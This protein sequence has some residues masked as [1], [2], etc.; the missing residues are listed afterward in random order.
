M[1]SVTQVFRGDAPKTEYFHIYIGWIADRVQKCD[2]IKVLWLVMKFV[3]G[4]WSVTNCI[5]RLWLAINLRG[6]AKKIVQILLLVCISAEMGTF[7]FFLGGGDSFSLVSLLWANLEE[8]Q[9]I[10]F[11]PGEV[12]RKPSLLFYQISRM[13]NFRE[14]CSEIHEMERSEFSF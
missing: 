12:L 8:G 3:K 4:L 13:L 11:L 2:C 14:V 5:K 1:L 7:F 10:L 6:L 9:R